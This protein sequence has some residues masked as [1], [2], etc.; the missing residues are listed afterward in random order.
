VHAP[1]ALDR[2]QRAELLAVADPAAIIDLAERALA[3]HE[4]RDVLVVIQPAETGLVMLQVREP[5]CS[6]RFHLG[7]V[8]VT[9]AEVA[10]GEAHG[11]SMRLG[12]DGHAAL[13]AAICDA[14]AEL[15]AATGSGGPVAAGAVGVALEV[16]ELCRR[17]RD[18]GEMERRREWDELAPTVVQFEELD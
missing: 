17:T 7:E 14:V 2:E 6:E 4:I 12:S 1:Y 10:V 13:G 5:V 11:W 9:R 16:D 15:V 3:V 8:V 18:Q